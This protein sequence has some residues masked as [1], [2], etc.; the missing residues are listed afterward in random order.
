[1][2]IPST[3]DVTGAMHEM[4]SLPSSVPKHSGK[5][6]QHHGIGHKAW[7]LQ[8]A[9]HQEGKPSLNSAEGTLHAMLLHGAMF[10]QT[11]DRFQNHLLQL[12]QRVQSQNSSLQLMSSTVRE[13]R[14]N[15][16]SCAQITYTTHRQA[17]PLAGRLNN[18]LT[19]YIRTYKQMCMIMSMSCCVFE[20]QRC[21]HAHLCVCSLH[22]NFIH[23]TFDTQEATKAKHL[24]QVYVSRGR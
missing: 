10:V 19:N 7:Q 20:L 4:Q 12:K 13:R 3:R 6:T 11:V 18:E 14:M 22:H 5:S 17:P 2:Q 15:L 16:A 8:T 24:R 23:Y 9:Q 21:L 1:M